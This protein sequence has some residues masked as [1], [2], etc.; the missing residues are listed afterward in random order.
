MGAMARR[1]S[2]RSRSGESRAYA[3]SYCFVVENGH[4][5][6]AGAMGALWNASVVPERVGADAQKVGLG[7]VKAPFLPYVSTLLRS[8]T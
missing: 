1:N 4:V 5:L 7:E 8:H 6:A 2:R 3:L